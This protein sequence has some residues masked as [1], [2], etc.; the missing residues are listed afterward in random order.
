MTEAERLLNCFTEDQLTEMSINGSLAQWK[1]GYKHKNSG[2]GRAI[3]V[4]PDNS[5]LIVAFGRART[6]KEYER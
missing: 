1:S 5:A 2:F 4:Y 6:V 3:Y